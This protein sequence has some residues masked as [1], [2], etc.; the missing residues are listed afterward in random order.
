[1]GA[2]LESLA[3]LAAWF[4]RHAIQTDD[5]WRWKN[6]RTYGRIYLGGGK[7]RPLQVSPHRIAWMLTAGSIPDGL[8][9]CHHCDMPSCIRPAHLFLGT[10]G[11]NV[12]D[13]A[14]KGRL[15][16]PHGERNGQAKLTTAAVRAIRAAH[17]AG[18]R[19]GRLA[20]AHGISPGLVTMIVRRQRWAHVA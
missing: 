17:A 19:P 5:C 10:Q 16:A 18:I 14:R 8:V 6:T 11:E 13:A 3:A 15:V 7:R 1:M 2:P 20:R 12:R 9:V 4:W